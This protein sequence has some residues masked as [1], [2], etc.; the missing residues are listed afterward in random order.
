MVQNVN[1]VIV[2]S[3]FSS[4]LVS[5]MRAVPPVWWS[6]TFHLFIYFFLLF[7]FSCNLFCLRLYNPSLLSDDPKRFVLLFCFRTTPSWS[8]TFILLYFPLYCS[9]FRLRTCKPSLLSDDD[10]KTFI[11][12][13]LFL[14]FFFLLFL[15]SDDSNSFFSLFSFC[16]T[17]AWSKTFSL[18]YFPL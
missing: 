4:I 3:L 7:S 17:P 11:C 14:S 8:K 5:Y 15:L 18:L 16:I 9:V 1:F 6:E 12:F 2:Y 13:F 10:P